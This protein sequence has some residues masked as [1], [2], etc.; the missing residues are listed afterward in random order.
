MPP[1]GGT[2]EKRMSESNIEKRLGEIK[3]LLREKTKKEREVQELFKEVMISLVE[4]VHI[5]EES[6]D[7]SVECIF[8]EIYNP[9]IEGAN[10]IQYMAELRHF[11]G[12][13]AIMFSKYIEYQN[14]DED[15]IL[16]YISKNTR[17][18]YIDEH[19]TPSIEDISIIVNN[20]ERILNCWA[21]RLMQR[22]QDLEKLKEQIRELRARLK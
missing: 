15:R 22:N 3:S 17:E 4:K 7:T 18:I 20:L 10:W 1:C 21:E 19:F 11:A 9:P 12:I 13:T 14:A 2:G 6:R 16:F 8:Y 5:N